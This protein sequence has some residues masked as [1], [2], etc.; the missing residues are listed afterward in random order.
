M[1]ESMAD[2]ADRDRDARDAKLRTDALEAQQ[3]RDLKTEEYLGA[4]EYLLIGAMAQVK[5][6]DDAG[7]FVVK[8]FNEGAVLRG[9]DID[10]DNL[11]HL[12]DIRFLVPKDA[13]EARF[14]GPAGTPRPGEPPNVP[15]GEGTPV[16]MLPHEERLRLQQE[17]AAKS[18]KDA[19]K[20]AARTR[21]QRQQK[22][23]A[24]N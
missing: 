11:R 4:E 24:G 12:V 6:K 18:E 21:A 5:I 10:A 7:A 20:T 16:E 13:D 2:Q 17:A 1:A 8:H 3:K 19:D 15:V 23:G 22:P 9:D 14:A